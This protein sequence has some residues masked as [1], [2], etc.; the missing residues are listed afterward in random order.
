MEKCK[1]LTM[2][3]SSNQ[4]VIFNYFLQIACKSDIFKDGTRYSSGHPATL[5]AWL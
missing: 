2:A 5:Q 1:C 4:Q 3:V